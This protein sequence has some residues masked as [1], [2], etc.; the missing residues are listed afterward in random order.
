MVLDSG[1]EF[2]LRCTLFP[3]KSISYPNVFDNTHQLKKKIL[4]CVRQRGTMDSTLIS[5]A[6]NASSKPGGVG[7]Q[8]GEENMTN[9][10]RMSIMDLG[11]GAFLVHN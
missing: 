4:Y 3:A 5:G 9:E 1:S 8:K 7:A 2:Q 11:N 6:G 10:E